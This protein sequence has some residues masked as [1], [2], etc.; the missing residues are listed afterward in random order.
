[1][2]AVETRRRRRALLPHAV[3]VAVLVVEC[4]S[5]LARHRTQAELEAA[6]EGG[7]PRERL[8]ALHVLTNRDEPPPTR[9]GR[10]FVQG[11]LQDES[12]PVLEAVF[13]NEICKFEPPALQ[14]DV[15]RDIPLERIDLLW[16]SF[17]LQKHKVGGP[18]VGAGKRMKLQDLDW[19]LQAA[20]PDR[21][22]PAD[23]IVEYVRDQ[24]TAYRQQREELE[25]LRG[26]SAGFEE[27]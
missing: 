2:S 1:M 18:V 19:F 20:N 22:L 12:P 6:W 21:T 10:A 26:S 13:T 15:I 7:T 23:R 9:F 3:L 24:A 16:R 25:A 4:L 5:A 8:E 17:V 11:L 14:N 27:D